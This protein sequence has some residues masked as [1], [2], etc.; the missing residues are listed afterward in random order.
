MSKKTVFGIILVFMISIFVVGCSDKSD[1]EESKDTDKNKEKEAAEA[2]EAESAVPEDEELLSVLK[3]NI[4]TMQDKDIDAYME[5][6]HP[7]SPAYDSTEDLLDQM[8]R[9]E[10]DIDISDLS[11]EDK[12][13][14]E[15]TVSF[16]QRSMKVDGPDYQNNEIKGVHTLKPD[17]DVWKIYNTDATEQIALDEDGEVMD[18]P[19]EDD[20]AMDG[21]V[22]MEGEY[23]DK[24]TD[25]EMPFGEDWELVD[26]NEEDGEGIAEFTGTDE[27]EDALALHYVE[28]GEALMGTEGLID[29]MKENLSGM[30]TGDFDFNKE[31]VTDEEGL[32]D[33]TI[34]DDDVEYDQEEVGRVFV[35]DG[36]LFIVR[37]TLLDDTIDDKDGWIEKFKEVK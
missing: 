30:V 27:K 13:E 18:D 20:A 25:L 9:Y 7:D 12:S 14:D 21:D 28:D 5:T 36:D 1:A 3:E 19:A 31:E 15:A 8:E 4:K 34:K 32:Y 22:A 37:Y 26:Y 33:F 24:L 16:T 29:S 10:L 17:D 6:I 2:E 11:V 35:Q 23:V